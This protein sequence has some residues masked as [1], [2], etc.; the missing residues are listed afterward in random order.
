MDPQFAYN[1]L[2]FYLS[3][4]GALNL[5]SF[6]MYKSARLGNCKARALGCSVTLGME[7][8]ESPSL[9][10]IHFIWM[11][12]NAPNAIRHFLFRINVAFKPVEFNSFA[13]STVS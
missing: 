9:N 11:V 10:V 12:P 3:W 4:F 13:F 7:A 6:Q 5:A 1:I 2:S 8:V